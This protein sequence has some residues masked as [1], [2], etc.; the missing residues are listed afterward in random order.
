M[1][2]IELLHYWS[3]GIPRGPLLF[4][5]VKRRKGCHVSFKVESVPWNFFLGKDETVT[6]QVNAKSQDAT[7]I[8]KNFTTQNSALVIFW[9]GTGKERLEFFGYDYKT[10]QWILM[11]VDIKEKQKAEK[12]YYFLHFQDKWNITHE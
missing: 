6:R 12:R 9:K 3:C 1:Y 7:S 5:R 11:D 10:K 4:S 2:K 8:S